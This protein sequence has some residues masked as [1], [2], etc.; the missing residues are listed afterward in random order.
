ML[1]VRYWPPNKP[2]ARQ[3]ISDYIE[4]CRYQPQKVTLPEEDDKEEQRQNRTQVFADN[5]VYHSLDGHKDTHCD[6][7]SSCWS[8]ESTANCQALVPSLPEIKSQRSPKS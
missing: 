8:Q 1:C 4:E 3:N 7:M 2:D 6:T 5:G